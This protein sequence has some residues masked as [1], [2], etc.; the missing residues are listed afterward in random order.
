MRNMIGAVLVVGLAC[1]LGACKKPVEPAAEPAPAAA[2]ATEPQT[3]PVE[4]TGPEEQTGPVERTGPDEQTGP[5][6]RTT[7]PE[8]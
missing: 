6:E 1:G 5:V 7:P 4:R 2:T 8:Q 3:G